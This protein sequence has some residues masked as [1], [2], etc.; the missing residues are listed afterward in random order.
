MH[1]YRNKL[2]IEH[3]VKDIKD[4]DIIDVTVTQRISEVEPEDGCRKY[5]VLEGQTITIK[6][7]GGA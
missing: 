6:V 4:S 3:A 1:P 2:Q 7:N 5:K